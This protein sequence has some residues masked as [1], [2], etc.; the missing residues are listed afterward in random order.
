MAR[1][2][3]GIDLGTT[4]SAMACA[5]LHGDAAS[6]VFA[7]S[8][9]D[10]PT[11]LAEAATLPSFLYLPEEAVAAQMLGRDDGEGAWIVGR[12]ERRRGGEVPGR[13]VHSAKPRLCHHA[14]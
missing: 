1:Y 13:V 7:V 10:T 4:N 9:W 6:E 2:S 8:Q 11:A 3:I 12:L 14:T 5:P